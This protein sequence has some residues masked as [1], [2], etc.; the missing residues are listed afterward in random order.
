MSCHT[1]DIGDNVAIVLGEIII[2]GCQV[3]V[4]YGEGC[5]S[6]YDLLIPFDRHPGEYTDPEEDFTRFEKVEWCL[7]RRMT[8]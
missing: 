4:V 3:S 2:P 6:R 5:N 1:F 8:T 7:L